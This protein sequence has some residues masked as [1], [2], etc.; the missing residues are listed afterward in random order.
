MNATANMWNT[1][2]DLFE[3][4]DVLEVLSDETGGR[5]IE[6][7]TQLTSPEQID[8][9]SIEAALG[10]FIELAMKAVGIMDHD[11][12]R[13]AAVLRDKPKLGSLV[14]P[15]QMK[16]AIEDFENSKEPDLEFSVLIASVYLILKAGERFISGFEIK[17]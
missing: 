9:L 5:F 17:V 2:N 6:R 15:A 3:S 7:V 12:A 14:T 13:V 10:K 4:D 8:V 16:T 1:L 11:M